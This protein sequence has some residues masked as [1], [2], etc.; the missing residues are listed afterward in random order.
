MKFTSFNP[1]I[2]SSDADAIVKVFEAL[3]FEKRHSKGGVDGQD[4]TSNNLRDPNGFA[5][6]VA[7]APNM[8]RDMTIIRINVDN[9][10]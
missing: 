3:G 8:E 5:V 4:I 6:D 9:F 7:Q 10:E 1:L 2:I